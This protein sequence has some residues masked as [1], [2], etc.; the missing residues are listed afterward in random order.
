MKSGSSSKLEADAPQSTP[1]HPLVVRTGTETSG[2]ST[3]AIEK[4]DATTEVAKLFSRS[5]CV[6]LRQIK[7]G[8]ASGTIDDYFKGTALGLNSG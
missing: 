4:A 3:P 8:S 5:K 7:V 1:R 2:S 6:A